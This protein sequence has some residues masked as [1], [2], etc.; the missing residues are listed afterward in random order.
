[1][2][3]ILIGASADSPVLCSFIKMATECDVV[4]PTESQISTNPLNS[5]HDQSEE[6]AKKFTELQ[7][8]SQ[9]LQIQTETAPINVELNYP[10][11]VY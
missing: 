11:G 7:N 8:V 4:P 10:N 9:V 6:K 1:M 3:I 5:A 2:V